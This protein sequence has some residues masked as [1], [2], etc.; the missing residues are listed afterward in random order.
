MLTEEDRFLSALNKLEDFKNAHRSVFNSLEQLVDEYNEARA[1][2]ERLAREKGTTVGPFRLLRS[3]QKVN[4]E[5]A[6]D[7]LTPE[8][9]EKV[10]GRIETKRV[11]EIDKQKFNKAVALGSIS[12]DVASEINSF[13]HHFSKVKEFDV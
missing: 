9:F 2:L 11:Y 3:I 13:V 6:Y 8:E 12:K 5:K 7:L 4:A 10:G 1:S